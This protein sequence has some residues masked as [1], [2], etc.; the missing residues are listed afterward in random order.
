MEFVLKLCGWYPSRVDA[1][2]G[3]F[4]Q[5]Q[6]IAISRQVKTVVL[7]AQKDP[8]IKNRVIELDKRQDGNLYEYIYY[9]PQRRFFDKAW[10]QWY[11]LGVLR[12]FLRLL[13][14][15]HGAP[16]IVHVNIVWRAA[17]W[18]L[19]LHKKFNW[20]FLITENS[21]EYQDNARENIRSK[22]FLRKRITANAFKKSSL[23]IPVSKQLGNKIRQLYGNI[24]FRVVPNTVNTDF[25][26]YDP[27]QKGN[28]VFKIL[29]VSTMGHQKNIEGIITVIRK[30]ADSGLNFELTLAGPAPSLVKELIIKDPLL[31]KMVSFTGAVT[32]REVSTLMKT[33][34]CLLLF[35]RYE[36]L[37]C[38]ILEAFCCGLPVISTNVGGIPEIVHQGNGILVENEDE[39]ALFTALVSL[40]SGRLS[41]N[42][43]EISLEAS[44]LYNYE[45]IGKSFFNIYRECFAGRL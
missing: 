18:A 20:P 1:L 32:Y 7:F 35:S 17:V 9:Y 22:S 41:F 8:G 30:L 38:V 3:D 23:F 31:A 13:I 44:K 26:N 5:R 29:H 27:S 6:A 4:V 42:H 33:S 10:S 36:N 25:F 37:P 16:T 28:G 19:F 2:S 15:E 34:H 39:Q 24:P 11:Y 14:E 40:I 21:T 12:T 45:T 43:Q